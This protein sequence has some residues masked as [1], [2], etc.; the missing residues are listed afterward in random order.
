[1]Q[2]HQYRCPNGVQVLLNTQSQAPLLSLQFWVQTGSIHEEEHLGSGLSHL[3]EHMVF[4]GTK[5]YSGEA[6]AQKVQSLGG[7]WNAYTSTDRTVYHIDGPAEH[8]REFLNLLHELVLLP[9]LPSE[10]WEREREVIRREMEMYNDD[11]CD[12]SYHALQSTL[13]LA[14]PRRLPVIGELANFDALS[15]EDMC[16]Y[17]ANHYIPSRLLIACSAGGD[18]IEP[19]QFFEAVQQLSG[20]RPARAPWPQ[21]SPYE[22]PQWGPRL[23]RRE[24]AQPTSAL[25]LAWRSPSSQH[26]DAAPLSLLASIL[27]DGR[28]ALLHTRLHDQQGI[29]HDLSC[30]IIPSRDG[31]SAIVIEADCDRDKREQVHAAIIATIGELLTS[32]SLESLAQGLQRA[33]RQQRSARLSSLATVQGSASILALSWHHNH[34]CNCMEE[35]ED[36][37][38]RVTPSDLQ[39]V[40]RQY[41]Q[42]SSI[43]KFCEISIDPIGS[44]IEE[45]SKQKNVNLAAPQRLELANGLQLL[46]R[47][48]KRIPMVYASLALGAGVASESIETSGINSLLSEC[49]LKASQSRSDLGSILENLG[50]SLS[51]SAENNTLCISANCLSEDINSMLDILADICLNPRISEETLRI[52]KDALIAEILDAEEDPAALAF[53]E[54]RRH[55]FGDEAYGLSPDGSADS[56]ESLSVKQLL[57][58]HSRICCGRNAVLSLVGDIE[59]EQIISLVQ[60]LFAS[61]PAGSPIQ[62][63]KS[64][65]QRAGSHHLISDKEQSVLTLATPGLA[66]SSEEMPLLALY[67]EWARDMAGPIFTE[68]R[69]K[70]GLAYYASAASLSGIDVGCI[71]YYLGC[72][73]A[74][75]AEARAA[76]DGC[77]AEIATKGMSP[78][79]LERSR[80]TALAGHELNMQTGKR[81]ASSLAVNCLLGI[82]INYSLQTP[83]LL[84][85]VSHEQI[86]A[87]I[88]RVL[89]PEATR[90]YLSVSAQG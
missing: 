7:I 17:H 57:A 78:E 54:L 50:A 35:W 21:S 75:L 70:R 22:Q 53:R 63:S 26:P 18:I 85:A 23:H 82:D 79:E 8:W 45:S 52:E 65:A 12:A 84:R 71:Y 59:P 73:P 20:S 30:S 83:E 27:G 90:S 10:E 74:Q 67:L 5:N 34:N 41:M 58:Q 38:K 15:Y 33:L 9:S 49:M 3:L 48:D 61:L 47:C 51:S 13:Y 44:N 19:A 42:E 4:K 24:F 43:N 62:R 46:Y 60:S 16:S 69:E 11:P 25:M 55:C 36:A 40:M 76:L 32:E 72:A 56:V 66:A 6:L 28:A 80:A 88:K 77:L 14:H 81:L 37:L 89:A 29:A 31:E 64:P 1:M 68:I 39:R 86:Q 2:A 87:F